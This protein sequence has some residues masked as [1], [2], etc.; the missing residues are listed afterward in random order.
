[1]IRSVGARAVCVALAGVL[2]AGA[3]AALVGCDASAPAATTQGQGVQ[4]RRFTVP[5]AYFGSKDEKA[6]KQALEEAGG[7]DIVRDG[8]GNYTVTMSDASFAAFCQADLDRTRQL[9]DAIPN[10]P[11]FPQVKSISY[12]DDLSKV[13]L[14]CSKDDMGSQGENAAS[15]AIYACCLHQVI[16]GQELLCSVDLV[17]GSGQVID[18]YSSPADA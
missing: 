17:S 7:T 12:N 10:S 9:L 5:Q 3:G 13:T 1:M 4:G 15:T 8:D 2:A 18:T 6:S 16:A 14:T 11:D